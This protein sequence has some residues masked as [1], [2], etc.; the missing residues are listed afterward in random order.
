MTAASSSE[1]QDRYRQN[2]EEL[3]RRLD[4]THLGRHVRF[5]NFGYTSL[6]GETPAGPKVPSTYPNRDSVQ[7]LF[8]LVGDTDLAG[9]DVL[10]VGCGRGGNLALVGE[11]WAPRTLVGLDLAFRSLQFGARILPSPR[12]MVQG[13]AQTLPLAGSSVDVV[14][15]VESSGCYPHLDHFYREVARVLR[16]GGRFLYADLIGTSMVSRY[17][18]VLSELGFAMVESRDITS[19]VAESRRRRARRERRALGSGDDSANLGEWVGE[20][21]TEL[22][23]M[24]TDGS[25]S[26]QLMQLVRATDPNPTAAGFTAD[27]QEWMARESARWAANLRLDPPD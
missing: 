4:A 8:E 25:A 6:T 12:L 24:L 23:A 5:F 26:Y 20:Y 17:H 9:A 19:N 15:N 11:F 21:G 2:F 14:M 1:T 27:E 13:D 7:L 10:D 3:N 22:H 16:P 18:E